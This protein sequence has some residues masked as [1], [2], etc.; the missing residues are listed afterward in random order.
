MRADNGI[1]SDAV[2]NFSMRFVVPENFHSLLN[3]ANC[4][5]RKL[6]RY[7]KFGRRNVALR[8]R[9]IL[10]YFR[11]CSLRPK[12]KPSTFPGNSYCSDLCTIFSVLKF[13]LFRII[14]SFISRMIG[15]FI[16]RISGLFILEIIYLFIYFMCIKIRKVS[17]IVLYLSIDLIIMIDEYLTST[18][19]Q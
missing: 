14:G 1:F 18:C 6:N 8:Q 10:Y 11:S 17:W 5:W 9:R 16:F 13:L 19:S 15:V 3:H 4:A 12:D 2:A 7:K